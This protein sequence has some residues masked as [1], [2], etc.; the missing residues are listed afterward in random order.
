VCL[1]S[2]EPFPACGFSIHVRRLFR[3]ERRLVRLSLVLGLLTVAAVAFGTVTGPCNPFL[4]LQKV[5]QAEPLAIMAL[6][7]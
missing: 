4:Y 2:F 1:L 3:P 6:G 5:E 7:T